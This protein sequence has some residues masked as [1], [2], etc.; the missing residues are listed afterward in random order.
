ML[1]AVRQ[2]NAQERL[3][4]QDIRRFGEIVSAD[5]AVQNRLREAVDG[6]VSRAEFIDLYARLAA[7]RGIR[8]TGPQ[9][10][11]ALQEQKQGKDKV[12]P[13]MVQKL[14]ALL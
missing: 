10:A 12:L 8:F 1:E 6:G 5:P 13:S 11:V 7:E 14:V 4:E 2:Q 3:F 9:L